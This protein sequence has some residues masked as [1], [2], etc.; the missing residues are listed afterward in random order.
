MAETQTKSSTRAAGVVGLAVLCSRLLG[1]VREQVFAALFG[2]S[3]SMD[4]FVVAFRAP[5]L[6][7]DL[8]A[9]GALSTAFVTTFSKKIVAEGEQSAWKLANKVGTLTIIF[10]SVVTLIGI[11]F[12]PQLIG[13]FLGGGFSPEKAEFTVLLT[14]IMWPFILLVSL[15]ALVMGLLNAKH[16]FGM[17]AMASSFFNLGSIIG[18]VFCAWLVDPHFGP[19][20][21]IGMS[22]G[23][24]I[25]GF[26]QLVVQ[27]PSLKRVGYS[28]SFDMEWRDEGV[29]TVLRLMG[30]AIVAAS[31][32]QVNVMVNSSFASYLGD[33]PVA[34]LNY[35]FRLMQLPLGIFGVA[36]GTVTLPLVSRHAAAG[37][38]D[39]FRS[40]LA[41]GMRL[42]FFLTIPSAIGLVL[43]AEPIISVIY[44]RG[45]FDAATAQ[46]TADAL[47]FYALGLVAYSGIKV[48]APAFYAV[49]RRKTP[50]LVSFLAI[51]TNLALNWYL[52]F[53]L[54]MGHRGLA[55][56]TGLV[57]L[58]NFLLLYFLM[59]S[60]VRGLQ[61]GKMLATLIKTSIA[62]IGLAGVCLAAMH[63]ALADWAHMGFMPKALWL[64]GTI[65]AGALVF[66]GL[67][68]GL[69]VEE[70]TEVR[71]LLMRKLGARPQ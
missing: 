2:G 68:L 47:K 61:G 59:R 15:A 45:R 66:F 57:A 8:F 36:I 50:M 67:A 43:L 24:V 34:W 17:P 19:R 56:S 21:L 4:A 69:R 58:I 39:Q 7:R 30:P 42:A 9:E 32:V 3:G 12:S 51:G 63:W 22:I 23:V 52:T 10:M 18:G 1:L 70:I 20:S 16:V 48:L 62:G 60:H 49:D 41:R 64:I 46:Q 27:W 6:L 40:T 37:D 29:R 26:L 11:F 5:N 28:F 71:A 35:A 55:L 44:Q 33:G 14:R 53:K 65:A 25:G 38:T 54:Q 13:S 31:A